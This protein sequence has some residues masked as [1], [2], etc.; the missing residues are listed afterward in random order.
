MA[1]CKNN[2]IEEEENAAHTQDSNAFSWTVLVRVDLTRH[3]HHP[4]EE[5]TSYDP[6]GELSLPALTYQI[7]SLV[8]HT[9][10]T[11]S[12]QLTDI[13]LLQKRQCVH[14]RSVAIVVKHICIALIIDVRAG[15]ELYRRADEPCDEEHE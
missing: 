13:P 7:V 10:T 5:H 3:N 9:T 1:H 14:I 8:L 11:R 12:C 4:H 15:E 6:E 2:T